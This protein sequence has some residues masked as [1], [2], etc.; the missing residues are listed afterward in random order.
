M[1]FIHQ[2]KNF[3]HSELICVAHLMDGIGCCPIKLA[4]SAVFLLSFGQVQAPPFS[5]NSSAKHD[6]LAVE[7]L[8]VVINAAHLFYQQVSRHL[9]NFVIIADA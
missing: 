9:L 6:T 3:G 5:S 7:Y 4:D 2:T 1:G 8:I